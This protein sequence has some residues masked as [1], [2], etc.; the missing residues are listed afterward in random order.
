MA[1]NSEGVWNGSVATLS[2]EVDPEVWQ[3]WWFQLSSVLVFVAGIVAIHRVRTR[4]AARQLDI[5]FQERLAER[6]RIAQELHDTLLQG[7]ISASMQLHAATN[8]LSPDGK[9]SMSGVVTMI[10]RVIEDARNAVQ[11]LRSGTEFE[12]DDLEHAFGKIQ[13]EFPDS[14]FRV[15][16]SGKAR[17]LHPIIRD[18][19]YR[20]GR[21]ALINALRHAAATTIEVEID[22]APKHFRLV[23]RDDGRG[24]APDIMESVREGHRGLSGIRERAERIGSK[25]A[26]WSRRG[27]GTEIELTVPANVAYRRLSKTRAAPPAG[28]SSYRAPRES[29]QTWPER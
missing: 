27:A 7:F 9:R 16:I 20:I 24:M 15:V 14:R 3:T 22:Y 6:T 10:N 29:S 5:R 1:S 8:Q 13:E 2:F 28:S 26:L 17:V 12:N 25:V 21:E 11:G 18:E 4:Q 23:V 19:V